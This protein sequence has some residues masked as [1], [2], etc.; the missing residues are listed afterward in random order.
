MSERRKRHAIPL[1]FGPRDMLEKFGLVAEE[2]LAAMLGVSVKT[3]KNRPISEL[4]TFAKVGRR[5]LF[6][7][8]SVRE[9][10]ARHTVRT[11]A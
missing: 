4:P 8:D 7:A 1:R 9:Y 5:R 11:A 3:L 2:D 10:I 6:K